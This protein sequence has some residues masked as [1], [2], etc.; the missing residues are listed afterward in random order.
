VSVRFLF[1]VLGTLA[2]AALTLH[3]AMEVF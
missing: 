2:L 3:A 1:F